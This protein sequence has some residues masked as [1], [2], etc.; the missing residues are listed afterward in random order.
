MS[1]LEDILLIFPAI[2]DCRTKAR[3]L[4]EAHPEEGPE[5]LAQRATK[6]AKAWGIAMGAA[7]GAFGNPIGMFPAAG[8]ELWLLLRT[9][10]RL[11]GVVAALLDP[12][13]LSD[14]E[15]FAA[16][17]L[18]VIFPGAVSQA[19]REMGVVAGQQCT[20]LLIRK[21]V[22]KNVLKAIIKWTARY[23]GFKLTQRAIISKAVPLIGSAIGG[24]WNWI[25]VT[26]IG[27]RAIRY[28][29][30]SKVG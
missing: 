5:Q 14:E 6:T 9:E 4:R 2:E 13:S 25:E 23:L 3:T 19:L 8:A 28:H 1:I 29:G 7:S 16:D 18:T 11:A 24:T 22:R 15:A 26:K 21:Y 12:D 27:T 10:A 17:V 30:E 20:K